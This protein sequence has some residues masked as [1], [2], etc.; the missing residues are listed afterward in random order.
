MTQLS[1]LVCLNYS[2]PFD[3]IPTL[4]SQEIVLLRFVISWMQ[5]D[6]A[7]VS[8]HSK[9]FPLPS[10]PEDSNYIYREIVSIWPMND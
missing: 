1:R 5:D 7:I 4:S 8:W 9:T 6:G 2:L 3:M 10:L